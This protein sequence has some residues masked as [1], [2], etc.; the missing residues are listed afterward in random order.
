MEVQSTE[1]LAYEI[2]LYDGIERSDLRYLMT[3]YVEHMEHHLKKAL[4]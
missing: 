3:D 2:L 1:T 4:E